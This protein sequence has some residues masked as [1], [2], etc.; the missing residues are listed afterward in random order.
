VEGVQLYPD[1]TQPNGVL[2]YW[3][4][5]ILAPVKQY[6]VVF[7]VPH[8]LVYSP[9]DWGPWK[10]EMPWFKTMT[11]ASMLAVW[12]QMWS[13]ILDD[14]NSPYAAPLWI[15]EFG[16][17]TNN[18]RAVDQQ[19]PGNQAQ[20]FH[21]LLRYLHDHPE[22]GW[23]F[24]AL[25]GTNANNSVASNGLLNAKWNGLVNRQL[26]ADLAPIQH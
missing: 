7:K 2:S 15:G 20:W 4:G 16:T 21:L 25:N 17:T 11:Y 10:W 9:H 14:P 5:S 1:R 18:P 23:S 6:P 22:V 8:Q 13:F 24:Y 26:Q 12:H 19:R 3:W